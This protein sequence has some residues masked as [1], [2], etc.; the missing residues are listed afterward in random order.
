[1]LALAPDP[2]REPADVCRIPTAALCRITKRCASA[3]IARPIWLLFRMNPI[4][5]MH[6]YLAFIGGDEGAW[7]DCGAA[8]VDEDVGC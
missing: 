6:L 7:G 1:M 3:V 8:P 5:P 2:R 4:V